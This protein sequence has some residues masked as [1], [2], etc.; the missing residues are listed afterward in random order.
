M[1]VELGHR[2]DG[3]ARRAHGVRLVDRDR[4]RDAVDAVHLRLVHAVEELP[5]VRR[6]RLDVAPLPFRVHGVERERRL[7][8][9]AHARH[10]DELVE[11]QV[12]IEASADCSAARRGCGSRRRSWVRFAE[13]VSTATVIR[14]GRLCRGRNVGAFSRNQIADAPHCAETART[15]RAASHA[16]ARKPDEST[17]RHTRCVQ[18]WK[19]SAER[20]EARH[21]SRRD[22]HAFGDSE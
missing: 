1:I 10:D 19:N 3:G 4:G 15:T 12:E 5:R 16:R 18:R 22:L 17:S 7:A 9:A 8:R 14:R 13:K 6:E 21:A 20:R 2:A 11:R